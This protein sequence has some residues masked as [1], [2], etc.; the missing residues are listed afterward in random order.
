MQRE[1]LQILDPGAMASGQMW[2]LPYVYWLSEMLAKVFASPRF[3]MVP[4]LGQIG[5]LSLTSTDVQFI[6]AWFLLGIRDETV[7]ASSQV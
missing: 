6:V 7:S 2:I 4:G 1:M 5:P 3:C